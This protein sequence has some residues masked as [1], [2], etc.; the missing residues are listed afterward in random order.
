[1]TESLKIQRNKRKSK[2]RI[3]KKSLKRK[4]KKIY[5]GGTGEEGGSEQDQSNKIYPPPPIQ[6]N[7]LP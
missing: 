1:M 2:G 3:K 5:K 6:I 7:R 4:N